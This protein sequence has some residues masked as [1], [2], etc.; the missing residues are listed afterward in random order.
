MKRPVFVLAASIFA[1]A[2][3]VPADAETVFTSRDGWSVSGDPATEQGA[4]EL[5]QKGETA[6]DAGQYSDALSAYKT[7]VKK[8]PVSVLAGKAQLRVGRILEAAG[9]YDEA[10]NA[11]AAYLTKYPK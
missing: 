4:V 9:E 3:G 2:M 5:M 6:T 1:L 8:Y 10:Y 11:Y 7:L